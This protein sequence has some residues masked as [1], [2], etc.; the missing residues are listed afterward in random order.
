MFD[1]FSVHLTF[2]D[3]LNLFHVGPSDRPMTLTHCLHFPDANNVKWKVVAEPRK[4]AG[5]LGLRRRRI[6]SGARDKAWSLR[7]FL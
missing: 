4:D 3:G 2:F 1:L 7:A 5:I 6:Q